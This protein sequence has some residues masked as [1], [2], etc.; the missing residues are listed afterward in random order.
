MRGVPACARAIPADSVRLESG[1]SDLRWYTMFSR[2]PG[3]WMR[4]SALTFREQ[5][6]K[7]MLGMT[8]ITG[9]LMGSDDE[10]WK[11]SQRW[12]DNSNIVA[13]VSDRFEYLGDGM[14]QFELS[15][16]FGLYGAI[17][18]DRR[19]LATGSEIVEAILSCGTVIQILKHLTGR[20]SP[21]VSTVDAG[22]WRFF[23]NQ[24]E[25]HKHVPCFDAYPSGHIATT[26]ATVTVVAENYPEWKWVKPVGYT[27]VALVGI[28]MANTGIHWYSDYP[29][30]IYLGYTFGKIA[31]HPEGTL[32]ERE[33][34]SSHVTVQPILDRGTMGLCAVYQF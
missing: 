31:A 32:S 14:P 12:Y 13:S 27:I 9:V 10:T 16:A 34:L 7:P 29:L 4:A 28:G 1:D 26:I 20:E 6:L 3:D 18:N 5:N 15:A 19:A 33:S 2:I 21:F 25:Y 30:G 22:R 24:I 11:M 23:P 17:A 8:V